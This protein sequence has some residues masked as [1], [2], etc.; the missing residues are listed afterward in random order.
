MKI[1]IVL[2]QQLVF[3]PIRG[4]GVENLN[5]MLAQE[6]ARLGH[7]V[8]A[9]S[10]AVPELPERETDTQ[11]IRHVR[12]P[13]FDLHPNVW[14]DHFNALR[15]A[16]R[17]A[18]ALE[19]ADVTSFHTAFSFLLR[20]R[21]GLGVC[22][23]TIH[24]TPKAT[25][26]LYRNLDRIY[27]G[28][29]AIL[30]QA[31][32]I[33]PHLHQLRRVYNCVRLAAGATP[34]PALS[35]A[36]DEPLRFLYIG[37]FSRDK[38]LESLI[39][40]FEL[41][42]E[43]HP[44]M[45]LITVGGQTDKAGADSGFFEEMSRYVRDRNLGNKVEFRPAIHDRPTLDALISDCDVV[46]VPSLGGETFNMAVLEGMSL[47][48]PVLVSDFGPMPEAIDHLQ[49]G[50]VARAGDP[51]SLAEACTFFATH[52]AELPQ[53]GA[54]AFCKARDRFSARIIAQEY[55]ADFEALMQKRSSALGANR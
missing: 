13:G 30:R 29:D 1:N 35:R 39:H 19:N 43:N 36:P 31:R 40:G 26:R 27:C 22:T 15:W 21:R 14:L 45:E 47:G 34:P 24:R 55:L 20:Y 6:F 11:G 51:A 25:V 18:P 54:R 33:D 38:G 52:R 5:W 12:L 7:E 2:G 49:N 41:A 42:L 10:R 9:Y 32:A 16:R 3:P 46:C 28:A 48:K 23:H 50:Y 44:A 4:G 8:V 37:R 17:V 53:L